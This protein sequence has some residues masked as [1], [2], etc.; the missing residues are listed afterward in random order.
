MHLSSEISKFATWRTEVMRAFREVCP[1]ATNVV[2][3][4]TAVAG[5]T[6]LL[7]FFLPLKVILLAGSPGVPRY[8]PFIDPAD[9]FAWT[10]GLALGAVLC[11]LLTLLLDRL[12]ERVSARASGEVLQ[13]ANEMAVL[14]NQE[15]VAQ[16][17]F[18]RFCGTSAN[19]LFVAAGAIAMGVLN[20]PVFALVLVLLIG[21]YLLTLW[22]LSG[23]DDVTPGWFKGYIQ[24]ELGNYLAILSA[25]NFFAVFLG[26][27]APFVLGVG[28]NILVAI[29]SLLI[30]RQAHGALA[31][32]A[33]EAVQLTVE[34]AK[35]NALV[36]RDHQLERR[37]ELRQN[38]A[39]RE[40][41]AKPER[42]RIAHAV[43]APHLD[44]AAA[45]TMAVCWAD[46]T[47]RPIFTFTIRVEG[48]AAEY[49]PLYY[50][51]QVYPSGSV[52]ELDN[53]A[54]LFRHVPRARLWAPDEIEQFRE[55][56][57]TCRICEF[58]DGELLS[59]REWSRWWPR[60]LRELWSLAPPAR[61]VTDYN[62]SRPL[63]HQRL[64]D[65]KIGR[66]QVA[67][68]DD[69]EA[70]V[71]ARLQALM[72]ALREQVRALPLY[73]YNPDLGAATTV[74]TGTDGIRI[75]RWGRWAL[76]P[77]GGGYQDLQQQSELIDFLPTLASARSDVD[78]DFTADHVRLAGRVRVLEYN[79]GREN[80]K[81]ALANARQIIE[82]PLI[83]R[84]T[85]A[86]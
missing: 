45:E 72:P 6:R 40:V 1:T 78:A 11:Y 47:M 79:I 27:L 42:Q 84:C 51:Q 68:D 52:Q 75:M 46:S 10:I 34:K 44:E 19:R 17:Y 32:Y 29:I 25:V 48:G 38:R 73:I 66:L 86:A 61:L 58:G 67:V 23:D 77:V 5:V 37:R 4:A 2:I 28:G 83:T 16:G 55:G 49:S 85:S 43:L 59:R 31:S 41:F 26:I 56:P 20:P 74:R 70:E 22:G 30:F 18:A 9:E 69:E 14:K 81:T 65:D 60:T 39:L 53:E 80:F 12:A 50:Q 63:L 57:F 21:Q 15:S 33:R 3:A 13:G 54:F 8:F 76:E 71:L 62:A 64:D 36:F 82:N 35:I 24:R 7:A